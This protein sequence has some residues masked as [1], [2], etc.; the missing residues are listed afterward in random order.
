MSQAPSK[1][2]V[3]SF[4]DDQGVEVI[5]IETD[6]AAEVK[7]VWSALLYSTKQCTLY[8]HGK[9]VDCKR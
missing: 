4:V 6:N 3:A 5:S 7:V 2:Y 8:R 1:E 9:V